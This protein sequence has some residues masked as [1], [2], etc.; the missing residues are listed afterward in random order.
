M[1]VNR[2]QGSRCNRP[3]ITGRSGPARR[4]GSGGSVASALSVAIALDLAYGDC[5]STVA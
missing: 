2:R 1:A 3:V 5:P 4:I